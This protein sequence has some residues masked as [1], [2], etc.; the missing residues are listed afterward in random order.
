MSVKTVFQIEIPKRGNSCMLGQEPLVPG[1]QIHSMLKEGAEEGIY[2]RQDYCPSCW[3]KISSQP[4]SIQDIRSAWKSRIPLK[5]EASDLP[6]QRDA[7]A[8]YLLKEALKHNTKEDHDEAFILSLYLARKRLMYFR[9]ELVLEDGQTATVYEVAET[10]EMLCVR[11][12]A[13]LDVEKVQRD[14]AAKFKA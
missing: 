5:K 13:N 6:K 1:M 3:Q 2:E 9:Q 8:M 14:L 11:K 12:I 4:D 10:E 7:R